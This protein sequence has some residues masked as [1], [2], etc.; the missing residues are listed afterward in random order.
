[1]TNP[2][3]EGTHTVT[4]HLVIKGAAAAIDFYAKAFG[5][6]EHYRMSGPDG[7][8]GHAE[9][10]IGDSLIYLADEFPQMGQRSPKAYGGSAVNIHLYVPDCDASY[11]QALAAGAKVRAPLMDMFWGDRYGQVEDPFGHRWSIATHKEDVSPEEMAKR[12]AALPPPA[13][14]K[15]A[16]PKKAAKKSAKRKAAKKRRR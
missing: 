5:A 13:P 12:M 16:R 6:R 10:Q 4:P 14:P 1:M 9:I 7:R 2:I 8:I 15:R 11:A 3:P